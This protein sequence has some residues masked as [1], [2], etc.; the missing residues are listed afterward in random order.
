MSG[1]GAATAAAGA[2]KPRPPPGPPPKHAKSVRQFY[3]ERG[4]LPPLPRVATEV[5]ARLATAFARAVAYNEDDSAT[6][7]RSMLMTC[8]LGREAQLK[9]CAH[10]SCGTLVTSGYCYKH[11]RDLVRKPRG[12]VVSQTDVELAARIVVSEMEAA[13]AGDASGAGEEEAKTGSQL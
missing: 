5:P 11:V 6:M 9:R 13:G 12:S 1:A 8:L 3:L 10:R 2:P 7:G 4:K